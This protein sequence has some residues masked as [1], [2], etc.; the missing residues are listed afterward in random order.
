MHFYCTLGYLY[1]KKGKKTI[2]EY[3]AY[4][5]ETKY[6]R[7][8]LALSSLINSDDISSSIN[9]FPQHIYTIFIFTQ[10]TV[11]LCHC[12]MDVVRFNH[13]ALAKYNSQS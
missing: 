9:R 11:R 3:Q 1:I 4:K 13:K 5:T 2:I 12:T 6:K 7:Y 10:Y 8:C